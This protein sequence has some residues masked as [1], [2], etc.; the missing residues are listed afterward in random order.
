MLACVAKSILRSRCR[1]IERPEASG[2]KHRMRYVKTSY[3][4]FPRLADELGL[5]LHHRTTC[6]QVNATKYPGE[7]VFV[8]KATGASTG[9]C[10]TFSSRVR[11]A[12]I[13]QINLLLLKA[14]RQPRQCA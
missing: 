5:L 7:Y 2:A 12:C 13:L 1:K 10:L 8:V 14:L 11:R 6:R 9:N 4:D 3:R